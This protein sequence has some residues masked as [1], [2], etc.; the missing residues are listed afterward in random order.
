MTICNGL[1]DCHK[2]VLLVLRTTVPRN[3]P[4]KN[5]HRDCKQFD[6]SKFKNELN[7]V[8]TKQ[9]FIVALSLMNNF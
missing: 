4:E 5:T 1:S 9:N 8:L 7:N 6:S 3:Q 2:V